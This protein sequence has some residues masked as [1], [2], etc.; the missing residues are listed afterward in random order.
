[1]AKTGAY[2]DA[3]ED[4]SDHSKDA[5]NDDSDIEVFFVFIHIRFQ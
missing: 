2:E 3:K 1:M 4:K 5:D